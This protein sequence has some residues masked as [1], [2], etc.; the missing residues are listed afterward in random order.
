M[1]ERLKNCALVYLYIFIL[2]REEVTKTVCVK[3]H[4]KL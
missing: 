2:L 3:L 1:N 4:V